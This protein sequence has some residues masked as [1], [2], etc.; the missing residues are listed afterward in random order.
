MIVEAYEQQS[1]GWW[2]GKREPDVAFG[3]AGDRIRCMGFLWSCMWTLMS[4][5]G[6]VEHL[7]TIE[8]M[9]PSTNHFRTIFENLI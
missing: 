9:P 5:I 8:A 7:A 4:S 6:W 3:R 2:C 1:Q